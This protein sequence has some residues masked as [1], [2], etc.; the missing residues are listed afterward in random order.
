MRSEDRGVL[1]HHAAPP[2]RDAKPI[3]PRLRAP[4]MTVAAA[5]GMIRPER[6]PA[7]LGGRFAQHQRGARWRIHLVAVMHLD[8]LDVEIRIQRGGHL[9]GEWPPAD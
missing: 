1:A 7:P 9:L 5:V 4:V 2:Q 3:S 8:D 6:N